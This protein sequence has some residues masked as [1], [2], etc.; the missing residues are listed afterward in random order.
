MRLCIIVETRLSGAKEGQFRSV[1]VRRTDGADR[2]N[3][4]KFDC[5]LDKVLILIMIFFFVSYCTALNAN[6][7]PEFYKNAFEI[8]DS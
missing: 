8:T 7:T 4:I 6:N 5:I 3:F 2:W 1:R